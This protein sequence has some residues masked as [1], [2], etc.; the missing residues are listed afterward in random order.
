MP[1]PVSTPS[2]PR[3]NTEQPT[4]HPLPQTSRQQVAVLAGVVGIM[5]AVSVIALWNL[6]TV[7]F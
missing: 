7:V 6:L 3:D 4:S 1:S 5:L 2:R